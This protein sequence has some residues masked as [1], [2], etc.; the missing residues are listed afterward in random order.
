MTTPLPIVLAAGIARFD[1]LQQYLIKQL[2][3]IER[4]R[5]YEMRIKNIYLDIAR[6]L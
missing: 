1:F 5:D 3:P 6:S 2:H 4:A